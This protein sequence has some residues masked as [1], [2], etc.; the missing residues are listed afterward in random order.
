VTTG[1]WGNRLV[2]TGREVSWNISSADP[3]AGETSRKCWTRVRVRILACGVAWPLWQI[4]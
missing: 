1:P 3:F 4:P 2:G